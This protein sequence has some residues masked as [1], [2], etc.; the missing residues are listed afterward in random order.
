MK[1]SIQYYGGHIPQLASKRPLG[2][3]LLDEM[4]GIQAGFPPHAARDEVLPPDL[5]KELPFPSPY[6]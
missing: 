6:P 1:L 4:M 3:P 2:E 5:P